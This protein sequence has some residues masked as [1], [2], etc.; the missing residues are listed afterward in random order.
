MLISSPA[1]KYVTDARLTNSE[2]NLA[3]AEYIICRKLGQDTSKSKMDKLRAS[4]YFVVAD[5]E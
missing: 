1:G 2:L 3:E 5:A 4:N